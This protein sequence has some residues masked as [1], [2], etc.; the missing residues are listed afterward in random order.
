[1][2]GSEASRSRQIIVAFVTIFVYYSLDVVA[3]DRPLTV[4]VNI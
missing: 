3:R 4:V 2:M 1:M